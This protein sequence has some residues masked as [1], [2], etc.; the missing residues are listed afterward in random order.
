MPDPSPPE[1]NAV[2]RFAFSA[3]TSSL[4]EPMGVSAGF[5]STTNGLFTSKVMG[6]KS[7][8]GS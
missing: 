2:L 3:A 7:F 8:S 1:A 5:T 4:A 6:A